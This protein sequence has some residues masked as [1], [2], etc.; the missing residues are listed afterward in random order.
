MK[1]FFLSALAAVAL[2]AC[3]AAFTTGHDTSFERQGSAK[4]LNAPQQDQALLR[5]TAY[6]PLRCGPQAQPIPR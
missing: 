1:L 6:N 2:S 5:G 3:S 4:C